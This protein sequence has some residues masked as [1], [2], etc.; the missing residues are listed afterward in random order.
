MGWSSATTV[1]TPIAHALIDANVDD[2]TKRR[3]LANL[4]RGLQQGD[5]DTE[6]EAL[7]DLLHDPAAVLA[8]ADCGVHLPDRR[9]CRAALTSEPREHIKA[10]RSGDVPEAEMDQALDA[11][12]HQLAER[13]RAHLHADGDDAGCVCGGCTACL[14]TE[15]IKLIDPTA[16]GEG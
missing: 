4:I 12:A 5:W 11:Y 6:D 13:Q 9:C 3:V 8:F 1:F 15:V 10:M 2:T 7:E 14:V 16:T